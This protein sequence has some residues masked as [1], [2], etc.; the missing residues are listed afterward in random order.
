M[1]NKTNEKNNNNS[2]KIGLVVIVGLIALFVI[3]FFANQE[4][5]SN[6]EN[7]EQ[8]DI[9]VSDEMQETEPT[10]LEEN[11]FE[12]EVQEQEENP[13]EGDEVLEHWTSEDWSNYRQN[14][15]LSCQ[16][17]NGEWLNDEWECV[18][19]GVNYY[20]GAWEPAVECENQGGNWLFEINRCENV[21]EEWCLNFDGLINER[22]LES[23]ARYR[24]ETSSCL[25][26]I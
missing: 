3:L 24:E 11:D 21:S 5:Y 23:P 12:E 20:Y 6:I 22:S 13:Y 10:D 8:V 25:F 14:M 15:E 19:D 9:G 2:I 17:Y 16:N 18:I 4:N 1:E 26:I 7:G